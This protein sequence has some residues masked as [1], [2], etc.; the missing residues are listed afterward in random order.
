MSVY[1][2]MKA[3]LPYIWITER[4]FATYFVRR[5]QNVRVRRPFNVYNSTA[6]TKR[7]VPR[8]LRLFRMNQSKHANVFPYYVFWHM[9]LKV[10]EHNIEFT[11]LKNIKI[12]TEKKRTFIF[13]F[14]FWDSTSKK[15]SIY[16]YDLFRRLC[17]FFL[18]KKKCSII[19]VLYYNNILS[20]VFTPFVGA[21]E[22]YGRRNILGIRV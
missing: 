11:I 12:S 17:A 16:T 14:F 2:N 21:V 8:F 6:P 5:R 22:Y 3:N 9:C 19:H 10:R 13:F 4:K 1:F 15:I 20:Y 18:K 7:A